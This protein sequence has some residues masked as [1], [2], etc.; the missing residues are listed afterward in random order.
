MLGNVWEWVE[1][2]WHT[3]YHTAPEDGS[4]WT[5]GGKCG[6]RVVRG[7]SW[8]RPPRTVRSANRYGDD[9]VNRNYVVG[10]RVA[11]TF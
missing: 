6:L 4:A 8:Y 2:C 5:T 10:F 7:G 3:S 11:R 9:T 1:D